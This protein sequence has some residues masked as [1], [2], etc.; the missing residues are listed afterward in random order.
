M[1]N[2][3]LKVFAETVFIGASFG[4]VIARFA[5]LFGVIGIS[6]VVG[7][8]VGIICPR[9]E[10]WPYAVSYIVGLVVYHVALWW[11]ADP[12]VWSW[13]DPITSEMYQFGPALLL[14]AAPALL[15]TLIVRRVLSWHHAKRI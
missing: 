10:G 3:A 11:Q 9:R 14:C 7:I 4:D 5:P 12:D 2:L 1:L 15:G 6:V 13:R 8:V